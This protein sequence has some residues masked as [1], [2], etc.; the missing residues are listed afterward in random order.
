M[1][2]ERM[3]EL[4]KKID[5]YIETKVTERVKEKVDQITWEI[6]EPLAHKHLTTA[7]E[8]YMQKYLQDA[9]ERV[10][11]HMEASFEDFEM[12]DDYAEEEPLVSSK[13]VSRK[14]EALRLLAYIQMFQLDNNTEDY[15]HQSVIR[16][17]LAI[18]NT[19]FKVLVE[20]LQKEGRVG[21]M[22]RLGARERVFQILKPLSNP[23][24][25]LQ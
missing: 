13:E 1:N 8:A 19:D 25:Y 4:R 5:L 22:K 23:E 18:S 20:E 16:K 17:E 7:F 11:D 9:I 12:D 15:P 2:A 10:L 3:K 6:I 21:D 14:S 24:F